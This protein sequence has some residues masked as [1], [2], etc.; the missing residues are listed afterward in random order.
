[1]F[2]TVHNKNYVCISDVMHAQKKSPSP[3]STCS[4]SKISFIVKTI[5]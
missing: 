4:R 3:H 5:E 1:M 2:K